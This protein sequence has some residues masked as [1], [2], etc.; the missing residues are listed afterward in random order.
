MLLIFTFE[1]LRNRLKAYL[2]PSCPSFFP[3]YPPPLFYG[4]LLN[5]SCLLHLPYNLRFNQV[6]AVDV[7]LGKGAQKVL[8]GIAWDVKHATPTKVQPPLAI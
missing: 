5:L 4:R 8:P 1:E 2:V 6:Y 7:W 3:P